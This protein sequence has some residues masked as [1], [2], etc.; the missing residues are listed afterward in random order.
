MALGEVVGWLGIEL[1]LII[2]NQSLKFLSKENRENQLKGIYTYKPSNKNPK[3][4]L[5]IDDVTTTGTT[6]A[7]VCRAIYKSSPDTEIYFL[8]L[9]KTKRKNQ[10]KKDAIVINKWIG[11]K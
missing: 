4:L 7:E 1:S 9:A 2:K 6:I 5:L 3:S 8:A 10:T 11:K